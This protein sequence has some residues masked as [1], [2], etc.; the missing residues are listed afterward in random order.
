MQKSTRNQLGNCHNHYQG[1]EKRVLCVCSAGLLRSPTMAYVLQKEYGYNTRA[2]GSDANFALIPISEV[3]VEWADEIVFVNESNMLEAVQ[4]EANGDTLE[5]LRQKSFHL[6][7]EDSYNRLDP[8]LIDLILQ[9][10]KEYNK[11][12]HKE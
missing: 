5:M 7:I 10:Y 12:Y 8:E 3:L 4:A 2:C 1:L 9:Q 11:D 6:N